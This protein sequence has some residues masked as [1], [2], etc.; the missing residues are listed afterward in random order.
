MTR[1]VTKSEVLDLHTWAL[2]A[3][4]GPSGILNEGLLESA[5]ASPQAAFGGVEAHPSLFE[6]AAA[7]GYSLVKNHAFA[8]GNKRVAFWSM[9]LFLY[10]NGYRL[11]CETVAGAAF[12][13][14]VA[15]SQR[16]RADLRDWIEAN[17][18]P[19]NS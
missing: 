7:L 8:D 17:A 6:K 10:L 12:F 13:M 5:I 14:E 11:D 3:H 15:A 1:Y 18:R 9:A 19:L 2:Q 4:G 16:T